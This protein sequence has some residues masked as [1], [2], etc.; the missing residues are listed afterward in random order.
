MD[1]L[2]IG[3]RLVHIVLGT[4]WAGVTLFF[5]LFYPQLRGLGP[6]VE[7]R[8]LTAMFKSLMPAVPLAAILSIVTGLALVLNMRWGGF[9][10]FLASGWGWAMILAA[11]ASVVYL[12]VAF[13]FDDP[14]TRRLME[15]AGGLEGREPSVGEAE[16]V[17][18]LSARLLSVTRTEAVLM[19]VVIA[20]M[21]IARFI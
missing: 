5:V 7:G 20:S 12:V 8:V 11:A 18:T 19:L 17:R 10:T 16:E 1:Y 2:Q 9:D 6:G 13:A 15:L 3:L 4:F 14:T 21:A